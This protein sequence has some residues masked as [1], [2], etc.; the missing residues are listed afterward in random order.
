MGKN[1]TSIVFTGDIGFDHYM[2]HKW[3]DEE[4]I[5]EEVLSF[6]HSGDHV[7]TNIEGPIS[8]V[9]KKPEK[10]SVLSLMHSIDPA[11]VKVL[12]KMQADIWNINNNHIMDAGEQ[13]IE[14]TLKEAEAFG[15]KTIGA[16]RNI[17]E[18]KEPLYLEE[19]GGIGLL[20]VGYRRGCK[21]AA[22]DKA[23]C[24]LWNEMDII[25]EQ[26]EKIKV[27]CRWC[28]VVAH[29]GEEFTSL[30]SPYTRDRYLEYLKMGADIIVCHH[31]HVP[32]NYE[33]V[34]N[35]M[36][37]YSLGNFI[38]DTDYQR[39]QYNTEKG[40]LLKLNISE[41]EY[42]FEAMGIRI[43][44]EKEHIIKGDIP[45]I[46]TDVC[47]E[48]YTKLAPLAAGM[49]ISATKRQ[50]IYLKPDEYKDASEEKWE[51][52]FSNPKRSGRVIGEGLDF[53][54]ICP[55][56]K[57]ADKGEWKESKLK[58]VVSYILEQM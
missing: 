2:D 31:P 56:A 21:G 25:K 14:D 44:R 37:F 1:T 34:G 13:G 26:I 12:E 20:S 27:T 30:P 18:A 45:Q 19:A 29:G 24:L 8:K 11:A 46:F 17:D 41:E 42:S 52:N 51:E 36:I 39:A 35:K 32:M 23:G 16:G 47:E 58:Q 4:L 48:E 9:D 49:F 54:I 40:L 3:E 6:L 43:D 28:I 33:T 38:F 55:L 10:N 53:A 22:E 50:Q 7:V 15:A 5:S 57:E